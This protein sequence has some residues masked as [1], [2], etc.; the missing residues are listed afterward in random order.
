MSDTLTKTGSFGTHI[1]A[2]AGMI[3]AAFLALAT[4]AA[5]DDIAQQAPSAAARTTNSTSAEPPAGPPDATLPVA[6]AEPAPAEPATLPAPDAASGDPLQALGSA[7][8]RFLRL[9][10]EDRKDEAAAAALQVAQLTQAVYGPSGLETVTP[11]VNLAIMQVENGELSAAEQNYRAAI[12][13]IELHEGRLSLRLV[14]PLIGLGHTYNRSGRNEQAVDS[15]KH[16]M[17][18]NHVNLGFYNFDQFSIQ[19]GL[20][21]SYLAL[22]EYDAA[23]F[24]QESQVEIHQRKLGSS[25]PAIVPAL[26]KLAEWYSRIGKYEASQLEYRSADRLLRETH[27]DA[28]ATRAEPMLG[29]ARQHER[30]GNSPA[31]LRI[32]HKALRLVSAEEEPDSLQQAEIR[33]ALGDIYSRDGKSSAAHAEYVAAWAD[34][35]VDDAYLDQR[36]NY[37]ATPVRVAGGP[38]NPYARHARGKPADQLLDGYVLISYAVSPKGRATDVKIVESDPANV[39]DKSMTTTYRRSYFRPRLEDGV[40]VVTEG[41]LARHDFKY[42]PRDKPGAESVDKPS[43][44]RKSEGKRLE[45]PD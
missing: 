41:L 7:Q 24:Y 40:P 31:A 12:R 18:I 22:E 43:S 23:S 26:Y 6:A 42:A 11:L 5:S 8:T 17:R 13:I 45:Q 32:L 25:N 29:M 16:A 36:N 20:T 3:V 27:G 4:A 21:E 28:S 37:F 33:V 30:Q 9:R 2:P 10:D 19:D 34:L 35:S 44:G 38:L 39:M 14:N 15:F 1:H